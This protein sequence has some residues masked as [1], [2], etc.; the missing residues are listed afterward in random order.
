MSLNYTV[1]AVC[2]CVIISVRVRG[3]AMRGSGGSSVTC[4][5]KVCVAPQDTI[6]CVCM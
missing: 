5:I 1:L 3:I 6:S 2:A 4:A